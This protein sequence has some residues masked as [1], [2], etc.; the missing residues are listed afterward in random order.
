MA[1]RDD[2]GIALDLLVILARNDHGVIL[3]L[4]NRRACANTNL[5]LLQI[6]KQSITRRINFIHRYIFLKLY[7]S[8]VLHIRRDMICGLGAGMS[9]AD[10]Y[11][12]MTGVCLSGKNISAEDN[13][14]LV[15]AGDFCG[16]YRLCAG[17][18]ND[19]VGL[20]RV[21]KLFCDLCVQYDR[22]IELL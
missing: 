14:A 2:N 22:N 8:D 4:L 17:S 9:A 16:H 13:N 7:N 1:D 19:N 6:R 12:V 3:Y 5:I 10:N 20:Y 15:V 21:N 18:R 11:H